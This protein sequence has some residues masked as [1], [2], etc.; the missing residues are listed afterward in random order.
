MY[1]E[2]YKWII[3][4]KDYKP[5]KKIPSKQESR[6]FHQA[7]NYRSY[8][9]QSFFLI[10]S[11]SRNPLYQQSVKKADFLS[12]YY[13]R[14][15]HIPSIFPPLSDVCIILRYL[16]RPVN[17]ARQT[18]QIEKISSSAIVYFLLPVL[19]VEFPKPF[20]Y[21]TREQYRRLLITNA[22]Q[23]AKTN[24]FLTAHKFNF[25]KAAGSYLISFKLSKIFQSIS[26][27]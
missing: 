11:F 18:S 17:L 13:R 12:Y 7:V 26:S 19:P 1:T 14:V 9:L 8:K 10:S 16:I 20:D 5:A 6:V 2:A 4:L 25:Q 22:C 24:S 15:H 23:V 27:S 21:S 3:I